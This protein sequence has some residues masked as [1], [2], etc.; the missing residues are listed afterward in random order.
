MITNQTNTMI[1]NQTNTNCGVV[2][3][4][5][6]TSDNPKKNNIVLNVNWVAPDQ[7][8]GTEN[9]T[10]KSNGAESG[11]DNLL[12]KY[13][14]KI[15]QDFPPHGPTSNG[16]LEIT[17]FVKSTTDSYYKLTWELKSG[18]CEG[19]GMRVKEKLAATFCYNSSSQGD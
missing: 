10:K 4:T 6:E 15:T 1:T 5:I 12:G 16:T 18:N 8:Y 14:V 11:N 3:Y 19:I 2:V 17:A 9:A 13:E 7:R